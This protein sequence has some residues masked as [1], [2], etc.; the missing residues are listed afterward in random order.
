MKNLYNILIIIALSS[1]IACSGSIDDNEIETTTNPTIIG[2]STNNDIGGSTSI[3][4][5]GGASNI[6]GSTSTNISE[7]G[8][9]NNIGGTSSSIETSTGGTTSIGGMTGSG[10]TTSIGGTTNTS[11]CIPDTCE[12][13]AIKLAGNWNPDEITAPTACGWTSDN[14][15]GVINCGN[16][17]EGECGDS[18]TPNICPTRCTNTNSNTCASW[19]NLPGQDFWGCE[20]IIPPIGVTGC[21]DVSTEDSTMAS[22]WCCDPN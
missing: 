8:G 22:T 5:I 12:E 16:C 18:G 19:Y 7:I 1:S 15:G 13:I 6:G 20:S 17:L 3:Y 21:V 2:G 10:G 14:C 4:E 11:V 9:N